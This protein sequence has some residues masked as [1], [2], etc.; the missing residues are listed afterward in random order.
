[1]KHAYLCLIAFFAAITIVAAQ[2]KAMEG[3]ASIQGKKLPAA[4]LEIPYPTETVDAAL[5][6]HFAKKG[7]KPAKSRDYQLYRNVPV[8]KGSETFDVY[9]KSERKS[10]KEKES[11][12][13]YFV[14]GKPNEVLSNRAADDRQG[15]AEAREFLND[16]TP[17]LEDYQL[18]QEIAAAEEALKKMEKKQAALLSDSTDLAKRKVQLEEKITQNSTA[19]QNGVAELEKQRTLL[20]ATRLRRKQP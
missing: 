8:G 4:V 14:L 11:S 3:V 2:P 7:F 17:H 9:V 5:E 15:I 13:V 10:R 12:I 20:E 16:F 19:L 1:M 6:E 18:R